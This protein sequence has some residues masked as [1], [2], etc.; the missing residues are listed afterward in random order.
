MSTIALTPLDQVTVKCAEC[1]EAATGTE[2]NS[3]IIRVYHNCTA[4]RLPAHG[5]TPEQLA[6]LSKRR[7]ICELCAED[8]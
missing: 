8:D 2:I 3:D 4:I 7:L 1:G 5:V 6:T